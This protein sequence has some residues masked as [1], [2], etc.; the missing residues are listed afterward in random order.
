MRHLQ[1]LIDAALTGLALAAF[2]SAAFA[3][4]A[5]PFLVDG[6]PQFQ[7]PAATVTAG[8]QAAARRTALPQ[9]FAVKVPMNLGLVAGHWD[10]LGSESGQGQARWRL[11]L[12]S[13]QARSLHVHLSDVVL[14]PGAALWLHDAA[15]RM[16]QGPYSAASAE[17]RMATALVLG[18]TAIL[19][20]RVPQ[21]DR[22]RVQLR[23]AEVF[24]G[25]EDFAELR[26]QGSRAK[27]G[28]CERDVVCTEGAAWSDQ[29]RSVARLQIGENLC[30]GQLLNNTREDETPFLITA[31]HCGL[32]ALTASSLV[33]YF[34]FQREACG[35]GSGNLQESL[36]GATF[37]RSDQNAD[38]S[39]V[40]LNSAPPAAFQVYY[41]G[42]DASG[43]AVN[44]GA[45]IHHPG[46]DE[47]S[48]SLFSESAQKIEDS[49]ASQG[50]DGQCEL[51]VDSW[52]VR[53]SSG[54][55][56]RGSSGS[57]LWDQN[58]RLVGLLSGGASDCSGSDGNGQPDYYGRMDAAW[59]QGGLSQE[60]DAANTGQLKLDGLCATGN[61]GCG[62][63]SSGGGP[64]SNG[65]GSRFGGG[66]LA[67]WFS[68][69]ALVALRRRKKSSGILAT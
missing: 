53:W 33:A 1:K 30:S 50:D 24:H 63:P 59:N 44:S 42:W 58:R 41:S 46:G 15:G 14:P 43:D 13:A 4:P 45:G 64:S 48:I 69:A 67:P 51:V 62:G 47:K 10:E 22:D 31:N 16:T 52:M 6:V 17:G 56:E 20:L 5:T 55:T 37:V 54:V 25:F 40:R 19:E 3:A 35:S 66:A 29:I 49:C 2:S 8:L 60:L 26:T 61:A 27:A 7:L 11:R 32:D 21:A 23:V 18:D 34:N 39:L 12:H 57:G 38:Y 28:A 65:G 9:Q 68:L 36:S